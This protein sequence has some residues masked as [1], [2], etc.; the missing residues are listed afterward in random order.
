MSGFL[1]R[2]YESESIVVSEC[3]FVIPNGLY[4]ICERHPCSANQTTW[5]TEAAYP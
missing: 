4:S 3:L 5:R 2:K 1:T